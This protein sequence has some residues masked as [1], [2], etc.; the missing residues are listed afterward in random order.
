VDGSTQPSPAVGIS[1]SASPAKLAVAFLVALALVSIPVFSTV[2]PPLADY[3][4]HLARMYLL[5]M[6][7]ASGVLN[8]FYAVTWHPLPNLAMDLLVPPLSKIMP[9]AL[10]GQF[11]LVAV[12]ALTTAG[13]LCLNR[14][15]FG[16]WSFWPLLSFL[17]LYN[18]IFLWGFVNYLF[19]AGLAIGG[20][21]LWIGL[22]PRPWLRI[23]LSVA[24][25][26]AVFFSH[27]AAFGVYAAAVAGAELATA[28][29]AL[30]RGE[31][32][33]VLRQILHAAPQ[34]VA[35]I[36]IFVLS[37]QP[38]AGG[39]LDYSGYW[40]KILWLFTIFNNYNL[41]IDAVSFVVFIGGLAYLVAT[42][43]LRIAREIGWALVLLVLCY[44][45]LPFEG[46]TG[47]GLDNRLPVIMFVLA[48]SGSLPVLR[49]RAAASLLAGIA[50]VL[51]LGRLALVER[52][53]LAADAVYTSD[54]SILDRVAPDSR[55][56]VAY[57]HGG[58]PFIAIP[59]THLPNLAII[60]RNAFVQS[61]FAF[62]AQQPIALV[63]PYDGVAAAATP[64]ALWDVLVDHA[65][66]DR[67]KVLAA[68]DR[69]DAV[70]FV[71]R[72]PGTSVDLACLSPVARSG[73]VELWTINRGAG[74]KGSCGG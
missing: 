74:G 54:L 21:A 11:F 66:L 13:A 35:P 41:A 59:E 10:A 48:I 65:N 27:I 73:T 20:L 72:S 45:A 17:L 64:N 67:S 70:I 32:G 18:R 68:L 33:R 34:F 55:L 19:G 56:A 12:F 31:F 49:W 3:P 37:W 9:L 43:Q 5:A 47:S 58:P 40:R 8:A 62:A 57:P 4:N 25:C 60:R 51:F 24:I 42:R 22:R 23:P 30:R 69:F 15:L 53:W 16:S 61:L 39:T 28:L 38:A 46:L 71:N 7:G 14:V 29:P 63:P 44:L 26:L 2:L 6:D 50:V 1:F 52:A 36:A